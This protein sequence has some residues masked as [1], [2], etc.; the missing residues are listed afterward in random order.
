MYTAWM[1]RIQIYLEEEVDDALAAE[2]VRRGTS[3]AALIRTAVAYR[4]GPLPGLDADPISKLVGS[5]DIEPA[6]IDEV[7]YG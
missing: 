4:F 1:R 5:V 7:V 2:A 3:K 6:D